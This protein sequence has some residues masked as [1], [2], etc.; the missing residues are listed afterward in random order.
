[1][2]RPWPTRYEEGRLCTAFFSCAALL[3]LLA[4]GGCGVGTDTLRA[5]TPWQ[6]DVSQRAAALPYASIDLAINGR[7]GLLVLAEIS[8]GHTY[9]QTATYSAIV[10]ENGYLDQTAGLPANLLMTRIYRADNSLEQPPWRLASAGEPFEYLVQRQWRDAEGDLHADQAHATLLCKPEL[11]K[12]E[13]PLVTL[14]LQRCR[15]TLV[16]SN[17]ATTVSILWRDPDNHRLWAVHTVPWPGA[18]VFEWQVARRW[19]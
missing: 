12:R 4:L 18:P 19:W 15:E 3:I 8:D 11:T 13:L 5:L 1:M 9:F 6:Q 16:W 17:G 2:C 7:G 10:L 14:A